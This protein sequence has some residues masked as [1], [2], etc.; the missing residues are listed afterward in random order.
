MA[1]IVLH[2][3][4]EGVRFLL[5][6]PVDVAQAQEREVG[7]LGRIGLG[8]RLEVSEI[9]IDE[10]VLLHA[11]V[12]RGL[13]AGEESEPSGSVTP[14]S[15]LR[16][17]R[18]AV[19]VRSPGRGCPQQEFAHSPPEWYWRG[20]RCCSRIRPR[21]SSMKIE[22]ARCSR[23]RVKI[24]NRPSRPETADKLCNAVERSGVIFIEENGEGP[25]VR[26]KKV[27]RKR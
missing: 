5:D 23:R 9:H 12:E 4:R 8:L 7:D 6:A 10:L 1:D 22:N 18:A 17:L 25:G 19:T 11:V 14:S 16:R 21:S 13:V 2:P 20:L 27:K 3:I 24:L 26:L 15:S